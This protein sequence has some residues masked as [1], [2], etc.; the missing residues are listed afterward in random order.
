MQLSLKNKVKPP[1]LLICYVLAQPLIDI[2]TAFFTHA[3]HIITLGVVIRSLFMLVLFFY[4]VFFGKCKHIK[5][6]VIY[7]S[8]LTAYIITFLIYSAAA[9]GLTTVFFNFKEMIKTFY[10]SYVFIGLY[11]FYQ[12]FDFVFPAKYLSYTATIYMAV[13][14][15]AFITNTSYKSY[16]YGYGYGG[17][18]YSTNEIS[19]I[20]V[21]LTPITFYYAVNRLSAPFKQKGILHYIY[22]LAALSVVVFCSTF[23]GTKVVFVGIAGFAL[24]FV[25]WS[26]LRLLRSK[27][28]AVILQLMTGVILCLFIGLSYFV[29]PLRKNINNIFIPRY[30]SSMVQSDISQEQSDTSQPD[31]SPGG[32]QSSLYSVIN[33]ALSNRLLFLAPLDNAFKQSSAAEKLMGLGYYSE[34]KN[35]NKPA[36]MDFFSVYYRQGYI[37]LILYILPIMYCLIVLFKYFILNFKKAIYSLYFCSNAFAFTLGLLTSMV[38]G[39]TLIAPAVSIYIVLVMLNL[40]KYT[41]RKK[42]VIKKCYKEGK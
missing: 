12:Q 39:H 29:S 23:I 33:W 30:G 22:P 36:E 32:G 13:V 20:I 6:C 28:I 15:I 41:R 19:S 17:W 2:I 1:L 21:I 3:G 10:F 24:C 42:L 40:L 27:D 38:T 14:F 7:L 5:I 25:L 26:L 16:E 37:G 35:I 34:T 4:V 8:L 9:Y 11:V 18:F 31:D